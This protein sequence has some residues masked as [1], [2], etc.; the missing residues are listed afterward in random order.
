VAGDYA[1]VADYY[2][3]LQVVEVQRNRYRAVEPC[4]QAQSLTVFTATSGTLARATLTPI[5][6]LPAG[7][8]VAYA[9]SP[10]AG[11]HWESVTPGAAHS[12]ANAGTQL[13]WRAILG[14]SD[15]L[16]TPVL[17]G[18]TI[19]YATQLDAPTLVAPT[20]GTSTTDNTPTFEWTTVAGA[21]NYLLQLD[22][23]ATFNSPN[24]RNVTVSGST[25]TY[26]P[27]SL[28]ADGTW[29]W[30]VAA[31]DS[32]G[33]LGTFSTVRSFVVQ[34]QTTPPPIPGFPWPAIL[35]AA[36]AAVSLGLYRRRNRRR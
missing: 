15:S 32:Q 22:T 36:G 5:Q 17:T 8:A 25:L 18:L 29:F 3:G 16:Q 6:S 20:D 26:T 10:D 19:A 11:A 2:M 12:F 27:V 28:L 23:V 7:T 24:L 13:R 21:M 1:C 33:D 31:E 35:L 4:A 14:T 34:T 30:R 9:L